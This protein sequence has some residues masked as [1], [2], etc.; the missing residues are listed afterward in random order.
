MPANK[1]IPFR[2]K[3]EGVF[4]TRFYAT[5]EKITNANSQLSVESLI[6]DELRRIENECSN[7]IDQ[8]CK[9]RAVWLLLRDLI[10]INWK[11]CFRAGVLELSLPEKTES[12]DKASSGQEKER[13]RNRLK[14]SRLERL[15]TFG[16]FIRYMENGN[17]HK[18]SVLTLVSDGKELADRLLAANLHEAV[19]PKLEAVNDNA[20][21]DVTGHRLGDIWRYFRLTWS[22][23][24]ESTPGR[25]MRYL[26]RDY[27]H[28]AR[29]VMGIISLENCV[30]QITDRDKFIGWNAK[31]FIDKM[32]S[33]TSAD[34]RLIIKKLLSYVESGIAGIDYSEI[35]K[36]EDVNY[37]TSETVF[38]L[39]Q[40]ATLA[41]KL[42]IKDDSDKTCKSAE[43]VLYRRKRAKQLA[44]LL[45][46]KKNLSEIINDADFDNK[47]FRFLDSEKGYSAI[48]NALV[49]QK[50]KHIGSSMLE[51][52]VCG[53]IPP[54]NEILGGK[55]AAL[56]AL[57]PQILRDYKKR[58]GQRESEIATRL[59]NEAVVRP[60]ELV[61]IGTTSLYYVG[62]SQY[63]RLKLPSD[64]SES[65]Y[66]V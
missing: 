25:T 24:A 49:A 9:C 55:L 66:D 56:L 26:I 7:N 63:N 40:K 57:S 53:A 12:G 36:P 16:K 10:R 18:R 5:A 48:R 41:E 8:R 46:S 4:L 19:R 59:K 28:P 37:P 14:E 62:S 1:T 51:L 17:K 20:R 2:P 43:E 45:A 15:R 31:E 44:H 23:P 52:N 54:Y 34:A 61:Y 58:Y 13:L 21:D 30:V 47:R 39:I 11:A 6:S 65:G 50:S 32:R 60:A 42:Q 27:A 22:T 29:P 33:A 64:I 38:D 3:L 35:C